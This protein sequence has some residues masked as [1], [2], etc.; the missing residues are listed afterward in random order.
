M[1]SRGTLY[2]VSAPSGAGKTSL[3]KALIDTTD[4]VMVSVSHTTRD[5]RPGEEDGVNYHFVDRDTFTDMV[6]DNAFLEHAEVFGNLYGTSTQWVKD[7]LERGTDVILEIDWQGAQQV[8]RLIPETI[9]VFIL[10]P[11]REELTRRLTGRGQDDSSIIDARMQEAINEM[12]H[13]VEADFVIINDDFD[14]ALKDFQAILLG[15]RLTLKNQQQ[16]HCELLT[17]LLS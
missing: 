3:V 8:R 13:Y 6:K 10:P 12:S 4:N 15:T 14:V 9:G 16:R 17:S 1:T 11:S 7:T 2:T 5:M